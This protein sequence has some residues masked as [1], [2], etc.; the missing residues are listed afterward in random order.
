MTFHKYPSLV[1]I[2]KYNQILEEPE[3]VITEKIHGTNARF[4][5]VDG[6]FRVGSRNN[7]LDVDGPDLQH[8]AFVGFLKSHGYIGRIE[9]L[10]DD[11]KSKGIIVFGEYFGGGIQREIKYY[12]D[13]NFRI[14][15]IMVGGELKDYDWVRD[16]A[17]ILC[18]P[19]V[20]ELYRGKPDIAVI[21]DLRSGPTMCGTGM[22]EGIVIRPPMPK[23][24]NIDKGYATAEYLIL[25]YRSPEF[26]ETTSAK[27]SQ[28]LDKNAQLYKHY[29]QA[30][31]R[32][33]TTGP[34]LRHVIDQ[35]REQGIQCEDMTSMGEV[36]KAMHKDISKEGYTDLPPQV[37]W[38]LA[39]KYI[40]HETKNLYREYLEQ[41]L[42][43]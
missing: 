40:T 42:A 15:D 13:K 33:Y 43:V 14:F 16:F 37:E 36:L 28:E 12:D 18:I 7:E 4:G 29:A 2:H 25:K 21:N 35:L 23:K 32:E 30:F 17:N 27:K 1:S 9:S 11:T 34:R 6:K 31:A 19:V 24:V 5:Y 3:I 20:P 26:E 22:R 8:F 41:K 10:P 38:G 39:A